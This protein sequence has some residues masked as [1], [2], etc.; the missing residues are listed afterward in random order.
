M[1]VWEICGGLALAAF[2]MYLLVF[3]ML[4]LMLTPVKK[5][6]KKCCGQGRFL[7]ALLV[8]VG[9]VCNLLAALLLLRFP[10]ALKQDIKE[11]SFGIDTCGKG[12]S[13][14][15][16]NFAKELTVEKKNND[17]TIINIFSV[18][19]NTEL[20]LIL[21]SIQLTGCNVQIVLL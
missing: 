13:L 12:M 21:K 4:V 16:L 1:T 17:E 10:E 5:A 14:S 15:Q 3:L 2:V 9:I 18:R 7:I 11:Y 6:L 8:C 19:A 20:I